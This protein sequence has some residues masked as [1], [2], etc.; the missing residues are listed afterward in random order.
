[1]KMIL[2]IGKMNAVWGRIH[3]GSVAA[4]GLA[5]FHL[6]E[7]HSERGRGAGTGNEID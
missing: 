2:D 3:R 7:R 1:M 5:D 4:L 6:K